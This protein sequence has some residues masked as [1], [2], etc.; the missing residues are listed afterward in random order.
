MD[1]K[2]MIVASLKQSRAYLDRTLD[3]LSQ[4]DVEW[5]PAEECNCIAFIVWHTARVEDS[6]VSRVIQRQGAVYDTE[7]WREKLGT[8][9]DSGFGYTVEQIQAWKAPKLADLVGYVDAVRA[10]TLSLLDGLTPEK[11]LELARAD[12]PPDTIG[13]L[14]IRVAT[15]TALHMGQVDYIRGIRLGFVTADGV[16]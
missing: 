8:P 12:R 7:G 14:L 9:E 4:E 1:A 6:F 5:Q 15:E 10:N 11:M 16:N 13:G 2:E 3:G